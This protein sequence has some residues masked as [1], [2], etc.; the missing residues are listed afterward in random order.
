ME[1][2][3]DIAGQLSRRGYRITPQRHLI[4]SII[5]NSNDHITAEDIYAQ[6]VARYPRVNIS[7]VY[8]TLEL[9]KNLGLI[10]EMDLGGGRVGYHPE[11]KGH[12]HHLICRQC[13]SVTDINESVLF[14]VRAILLQAFN[15]DADLKHLAISGLCEKC[16]KD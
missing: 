3:R 16:K 9:L 10:Y 5:E 13:G 4:L 15:F 1:H 7:T 14:S 6:V 2:H 11:G 12:H 8:R